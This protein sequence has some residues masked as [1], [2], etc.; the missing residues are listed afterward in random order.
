MAVRDVLVVNDEWSGR[1]MG[2]YRRALAAK[3]FEVVVQSSSDWFPVPLVRYYRRAG[4]VLAAPGVLWTRTGAR[5]RPEHLYQP[6]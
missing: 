4:P 5:L 2:E 6:Q 3:Q 1:L